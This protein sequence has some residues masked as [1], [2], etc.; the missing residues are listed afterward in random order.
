MTTMKVR[1]VVQPDGKLVLDKLPFAA[2]ETVEVQ[3]STTVADPTE[4][5]K[6]PLRGLTPYKYDDPFG[7][8]CD[9]DQWEYLT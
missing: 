8:A 2:G 7:P 3:V 5:G 4:G 9:S 6:Y 1:A